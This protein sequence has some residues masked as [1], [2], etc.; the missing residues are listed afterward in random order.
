MKEIV[1]DIFDI[2][3]IANGLKEIENYA[4]KLNEKANEICKRLADIGL[5]VATLKF[6]TAEY[7]TTH[8]I[9]VRVEPYMDGYKV[10]AEGTD[11]LFVEFGTGQIHA[12]EYGNKYNLPVGSWS[13]GPEGKGHWDNPNGWWYPGGGDERTFGNPP[14]MAMWEAEKQS[15][16]QLPQI[17]KEVF[18]E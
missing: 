1:I 5:E 17:V 11:V 16:A 3:S 8:D 6:L 15:I 13:D 14:A 12:N 9:E 7:P 18:K 2:G 4:N 10:I